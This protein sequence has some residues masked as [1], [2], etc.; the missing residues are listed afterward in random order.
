MGD[1]L[2]LS[3]AAEKNMN[4]YLKR[5]DQKTV[6][7]KML[8]K[9]ITGL[10]KNMVEYEKNAKI[11]KHAW[12]LLNLKDSGFTGYLL[13]PKAELSSW[14]L[15]LE[16]SRNGTASGNGG[17]SG[18]SRKEKRDKDKKDSNFCETENGRE[19]FSGGSGKRSKGT[20]NKA[21]RKTKQ[22]KREEN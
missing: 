11:E 1:D 17:Y 20:S 19:S 16:D 13:G 10:E 4:K 6:A 12:N 14:L 5:W 7:M 9:E 15:A 21:R 18:G 2:K 22:H 8:Q 3:Q